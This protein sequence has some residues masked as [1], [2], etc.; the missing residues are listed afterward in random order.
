[1]SSQI[2]A[3]QEVVEKKL[4]AFNDQLYDKNKHALLENILSIAEE[5]TNIR[6]EKL[7]YG[8]I[9]ALIVYIIVGALVQFLSNVVGFVYP[10][11]RSI[12]AVRSLDKEDDTQWLIYWIVFSSFSILDFSV[13][14]TLPFY[15]LFKIAFL[16]YLYLPMFNGATIIYHAFVDPTCTF[17]ESYFSAK[18]A[19]ED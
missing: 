14:T 5:K 3:Y 10:A 1:M 12:K 11:W 17:V 13:F 7:V 6:R 4:R 8:V 9:I 18:E 16:M 19:K 15:W 2:R